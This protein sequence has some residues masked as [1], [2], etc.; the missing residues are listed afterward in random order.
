MPLSVTM[1]QS[2]QGSPPLMV[3]SITTVGG[4]TETPSSNS[5]H[6][7]D[8]TA[9]ELHQETSLTLTKD[10]MAIINPELFLELERFRAV[11]K[12]NTIKT[13]THF[14][15]NPVRFERIENHEPNPTFHP[16]QRL[17]EE[18]RKMTWQKV[19]SDTRVIY[20]KHHYKNKTKLLPRCFIPPILHA[21]H[22]AR[23]TGLETYEKLTYGGVFLGTYIN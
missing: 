9:D 22:E 10:N 5:S 18:L 2:T 14:E 6:Q 3:Q 7:E 12:S 11:M 4:I 17:P 13:V 15:S 8:Q 1:A 20:I 23:V 21:C 19:A 16:F